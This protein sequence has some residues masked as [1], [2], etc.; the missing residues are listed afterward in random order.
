MKTL[1]KK[2]L[3]IAHLLF[4]IISINGFN[5]FFSRGVDSVFSLDGLGMPLLGIPLLCNVSLMI[6]AV[7]FVWLINKVKK[8][9]KW[10]FTIMTI[11]FVT[12]FELSVYAYCEGKGSIE[13]ENP[14][15]PLGVLLIYFKSTFLYVLIFHLSIAAAVYLNINVLIERFLSNRRLIMYLFCAL[16][17]AILS[18]ILNYALFNYFIDPLFPKLFYIS[19]FNVWELIVIMILYIAITTA[20]F[21]LWQYNL[22][23]ISKR[24]QIRNELAALKAQINPHFLFNNLNT[25]YA[26]AERGDTRTK[27]VIL[28]LSDFLRYVIYDTTSNKI[29]LLKEIDI[30]KTYVDL[31]KER[32]NQNIHEVILNLNVQSD[33]ASIA[34]LLLLP[35]VENCFKHGLGTDKGTIKIDIEF[36][37]HQ[38]LFHSENKKEIRE[39]ETNYQGVGIKNVEKRLYLLYPGRHFL[40]FSEQED[41]FIVDLKVRLD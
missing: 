6:V 22:M 37:D 38:L 7:P 41:H 5:L 31:Q 18:G 2:P 29:P 34:P 35:L 25:I 26:M 36:S 21:L 16:G 28:K 27:D 33:N 9:T 17:L 30:I 13:I 10:I 23:L 19:W 32:I 39:I 4:W 15:Q 20:V 1:N 12:L 8:S 40:N 3:I 24:E 11:I 14:L